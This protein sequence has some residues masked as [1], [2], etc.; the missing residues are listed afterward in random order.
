MVCEQNYYKVL[1]EEEEEEEE[2]DDD[3]NV[4]EIACV[5]AGLGGGVSKKRASCYEVKAD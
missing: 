5:G 4:H 2:D 3:D 1:N